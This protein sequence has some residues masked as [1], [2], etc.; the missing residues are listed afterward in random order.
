MPLGLLLLVAGAVTTKRMTDAKPASRGQPRIALS[1]EDRTGAS[2][3]KS[4]SRGKKSEAASL[5]ELRG[6]FLD[7]EL[8]DKETYRQAV[9]LVGNLSLEA[10]LELL[11]DPEALAFVKSPEGHPQ[12]PLRHFIHTL[13]WLRFGEL[14]P[15]LALQRAFP[16]GE[17]SSD[18]NV[19][20]DK[21][22]E[23]VAK[24][25]PRMAFDS[26]KAHFANASEDDFMSLQ[27]VTFFACDF[28]KNWA[29]KSPEAAFA[30]LGE[31]GST[32]R[33]SAYT[34][35]TK[36]L[37]TNSDWKAEVAKFEQL[38]SDAKDRNFKS[39]SVVCALAS[40]WVLADPDAAFAWVG[41]LPVT[42]APANASIFELPGNPRSDAY[43][44]MIA[45]WIGTEP[46]EAMAWLKNWDAPGSSDHFYARIIQ[47]RG[48][49]DV[50]ISSTA[51]ALISDP[52]MRDNVVRKVL[53]HNF[54]KR[55]VLRMW[56]NSP[57]LSPELRAEV[58][59]AIRVRDEKGSGWTF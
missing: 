54:Q 12:F 33:G 23:G 15:E 13:L 19:L 29:E 17:R 35:Y 10:V 32:V 25:N 46:D 4:K 53:S 37:P 1:P 56:E 47:Y 44:Q 7:T 36:C 39:Q 11:D 16:D 21:V 26:W 45:A 40:K 27:P 9:A 50:A 55:E 24:V 43:A 22:L 14:A 3:S 2:A 18:K 41:S 59:E 34:G 42:P 20:I 8:G 51:L 28:F 38:F 5:A 30:A 31:L 57:Q 58:T 6:M 49:E 48:S 52:A